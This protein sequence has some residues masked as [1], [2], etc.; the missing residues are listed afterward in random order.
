MEWMLQL[1]KWKEKGKEEAE[2]DGAVR[3]CSCVAVSRGIKPMV[4]KAGGG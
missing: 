2:K 1:V 4:R 3:Y